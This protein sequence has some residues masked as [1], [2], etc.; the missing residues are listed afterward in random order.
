MCPRR[1]MNI[2]CADNILVHCTWLD[3]HS[4]L[5]Q[6]ASLEAAALIIQAKTSIDHHI[7]IHVSI[8]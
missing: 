2:R 5:L 6:Q 8:K 4:L 1:K 3:L 7:I